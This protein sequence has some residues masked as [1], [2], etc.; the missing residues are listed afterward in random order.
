MHS[1]SAHPFLAFAINS[2]YSIVEFCA[3]A[4]AARPKI[5][6][7]LVSVII[8]VV[9]FDA[10]ELKSCSNCSLATRGWDIESET[11]GVM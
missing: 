5:L 8:D 10:F 4:P 1:L 9:M 2:L 6:V 7:F 11:C 3:S